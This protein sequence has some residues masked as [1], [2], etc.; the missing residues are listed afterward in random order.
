MVHPTLRRAGTLPATTAH[1]A[2]NPHPHASLLLPVTRARD[3]PNPRP[4]P[5]PP[6]RWPA[7]TPPWLSPQANG[8][9][10][11]LIIDVIYMLCFVCSISLVA[12]KGLSELYKILQVTLLSW[13][14]DG[15]GVVEFHEV[16]GAFRAYAKVFYSLIRRR[17]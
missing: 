12:L 8:T 14:T 2:P 9:D 16:V 1:D 6:S 7:L 11:E 15:D 13:D 10:V 17:S 4:P 3:A 5:P